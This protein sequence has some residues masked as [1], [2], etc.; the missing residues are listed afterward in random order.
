VGAIF[1]KSV[2]LG[3]PFPP[4]ASVL[5]EGAVEA[6]RLAHRAAIRS[7]ALAAGVRMAARPEKQG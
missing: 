7:A 5:R 6:I 2:K 4:E 3:L 1:G